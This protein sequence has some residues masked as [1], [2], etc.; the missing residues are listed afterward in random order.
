MFVPKIPTPEMIK[1][2]EERTQA[3]IDR[4]AFNMVLF[5]GYEG[6]AK[7]VLA[8]R[9]RIHD[10]SKFSPQERLGYIWL[11]E[12]HRARRVGE[13]F[14]FPNLQISEAVRNAT[15]HHIYTN[16]HHP[17]SQVD[18]DDMPLL[19]LIEMVSDWTAMS[20]ELNQNGGSAKVWAEKNIDEKW[21]FND[22][23][24]AKIFDLIAFIDRKLGKE[25]P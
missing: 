18:Q 8:S 6:I 2:Y 5:A 21:S 12:M 22:A 23:T 7:E 15:R 17:E 10:Q 24:K 3:H 9:G 4:V 1:H 11:T 19:D 20:Q 25:A 14:E 16:A 13:S